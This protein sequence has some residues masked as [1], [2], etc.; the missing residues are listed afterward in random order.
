V[1]ATNYQILVEQGLL[2]QAQE[3]LGRTTGGT[4]SIPPAD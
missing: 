1:L 2:G 4:T 3:S